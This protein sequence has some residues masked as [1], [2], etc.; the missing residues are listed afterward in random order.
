[1]A[2]GAALA[3]HR[4]RLRVPDDVSLVGFD[5]VAGSVYCV[6]PLTTVHHP[7]HELGELAARAM[8]QLLAGEMPTLALP[9][10]RL[11]VREST[12]EPRSPRARQQRD[13][14]APSPR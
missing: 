11:M 3:L 8:L 2:F 10:P 1:M 13:P 6:P 12:R 5:D 9:A 4:R 7:V 14:A